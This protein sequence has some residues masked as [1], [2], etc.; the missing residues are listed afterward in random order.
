M[1]GEGE[2]GTNKEREG[3]GRKQEGRDGWRKE[4]GGDRR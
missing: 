2:R 3:V 4:G 1:E